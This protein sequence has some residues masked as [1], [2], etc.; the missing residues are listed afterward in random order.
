VE[1]IIKGG[2]IGIKEHSESSFNQVKPSQYAD[3]DDNKTAETT[4]STTSIAGNSTKSKKITRKKD[5]TYNLLGISIAYAASVYSA[6]KPFVNGIDGTFYI[7]P[8]ENLSILAGTRIFQTLK[9]NS[10]GFDIAVKHYPIYVGLSYLWTFHHLETGPSATF[11]IDIYTDNTTTQ[12][13]DSQVLKG[14]RQIGLGL[15]FH[16]VMNFRLS[17][18]IDLFFSPGTEVMLNKIEYTIEKNGT[19]APV[20]Q[21]WTLRPLLLVGFKVRFL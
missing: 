21:S 5:R 17:S 1:A 7:Q 18:N 16:L 11:F 6:K 14:S 9:Y 4:K 20:L 13:T 8:R 2:Q 19:R 15:S 10:D 12:N 3:A